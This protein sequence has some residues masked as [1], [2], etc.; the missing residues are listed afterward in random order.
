MTMVV[1]PQSREFYSSR[2][3]LNDNALQTIKGID[4]TRAHDERAVECLKR[5]YM[6]EIDPR[7]FPCTFQTSA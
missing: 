5:T 3:V 7:G 1:P 6:C 4:V 2:P